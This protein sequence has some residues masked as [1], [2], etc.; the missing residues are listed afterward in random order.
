M[1]LKLS[2]FIFELLFQGAAS[3][4]NKSSEDYRYIEIS[5]KN[6]QK[7]TREKLRRDQQ[8]IQ[9]INFSNILSTDKSEATN[10]SFPHLC[11]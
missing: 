7:C 6:A 3:I 5:I 9:S 1:Y 2:H 11:I 10:L 8:V 4:Y